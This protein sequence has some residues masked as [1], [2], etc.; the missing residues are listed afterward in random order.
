MLCA[1]EMEV[2]V[3][4]IEELTTTEE[5]IPQTSTP[6][7]Q[8]SRSSRMRSIRNKGL[9]GYTKRKRKKKTNLSSSPVKRLSKPKPG[10]S[11]AR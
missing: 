1:T 11:H 7:Q 10:K 5:V 3:A 8:S 4:A 2:E 6:Q 9:R